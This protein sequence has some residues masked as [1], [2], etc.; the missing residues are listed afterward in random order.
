LK[1][2]V[3]AAVAV[4]VGSMVLAVVVLEGCYIK[5]LSLFHQE[6]RPLQSVLGGQVR[7]VAILVLVVKLRLLVVV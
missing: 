6:R 2:C 5:H 7:K 3:L 4:A 1:S